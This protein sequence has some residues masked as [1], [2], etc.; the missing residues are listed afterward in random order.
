ME[1]HV[2]INDYYTFPKY[3][4]NKYG[5]NNQ[6]TSS[7]IQLEIIRHLSIFPGKL[8][9]SFQIIYKTVKYYLCC[10]FCFEVE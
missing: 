4:E 3:Q 6:Y 8:D 2:S 7:V 9:I 5:I 1:S 10:Q